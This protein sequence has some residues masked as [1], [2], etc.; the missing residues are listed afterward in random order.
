MVMEGDSYSRGCRFESQH[1][2]LDGHFYTKRLKITKK[3]ARN[4]P[5]LKTMLLK[6]LG[7]KLECQHS[8]ARLFLLYLFCISV[9]FNLALTQS[10]AK[11]LN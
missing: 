3:D 8:G 2:I 9:N 11:A 6:V 7:N 1:R 10:D 4:G 5:F